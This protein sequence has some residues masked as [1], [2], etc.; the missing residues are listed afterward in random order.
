[1]RNHLKIL[2]QEHFANSRIVAKSTRR[3]HLPSGLADVDLVRKEIKTEEGIAKRRAKIITRLANSI[4]ITSG[5]WEWGDVLFREGDRAIF[6][7]IVAARHIA[8]EAFRSEMSLNIT[9]AAVS[10]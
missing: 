8:T 4:A 2:W 3:K 6:N 9:A 7:R 5:A 1:M 10:T